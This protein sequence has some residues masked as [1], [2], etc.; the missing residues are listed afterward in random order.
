MR[1]AREAV[2]FHVGLGRRVA[3]DGDVQPALGQHGQ[4]LRAL[5][6]REPEVHVGV[7]P[8]ELAEQ[9]RREVVGGLHHAQVQ[10]PAQATRGL[11][12]A[13]LGVEG[14]RLFGRAHLRQDDARVPQQL[15]PGVAQA[16][17]VGR[18][19]QGRTQLLFQLAHHHRDGGLR[20]RQLFGRAR[21]AAA[22]GHRLEHPQMPDLQ[23]HHLD[24]SSGHSR[25]K[26]APQRA[27]HPWPAG[28]G[29]KYKAS[30]SI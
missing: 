10:Q 17:A 25:T 24:F 5:G 27:R 3:G 18:V 16:F 11:G 12:A 28:H 7:A 23:L 29:L 9:A 4:D 6:H 2:C 21:E 30:L 1:V 26:T 19:E 8:V 20:Q 14:H 22:A 13:A 15:L